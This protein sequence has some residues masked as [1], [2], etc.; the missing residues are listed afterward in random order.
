MN[1]NNVMQNKTGQL[2]EA[3]MQNKTGQL[4]EAAMQNGPVICIPRVIG[5]ITKM[6][7]NSIFKRL[8]WGKIENIVI[9]NSNNSNKQ[10]KS[11]WGFSN[12]N[13]NASNMKWRNVEN[14]NY[15]RGGSSDSGCGSSD[16]GCGSS[17]SGCWANY[18]DNIIQ[19]NCIF[20]YLKWFNNSKS[21]EIK[22]K[23]LNNE[24]IKLICSEFEFWKL[25]A[26]NKTIK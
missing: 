9:V 12:S 25:Y 5:K 24:S 17:D 14:K 15:I 16:S 6:Q 10:N 2:R 22:N 21:N 13:G 20:V 4:R 8:S 23:L 26:K 18:Y 19:S 7:V 11:K 3:A 1:V